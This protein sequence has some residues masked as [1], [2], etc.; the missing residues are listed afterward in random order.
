MD[1]TG[2]LLQTSLFGDLAPD[3]VEELLPDL[4]ERTYDRAETV[5]LEGDPADAVVV[6]A[7][8]QL[9]AHRLSVDGREVIVA[10]YSGVAVTGEVGAFHPAGVRW[11]GLTAMTPARCLM[12]RRAPLLDFLAR[13]PVAMRRMLESLSMAAVRAANSFSGLAFDDIGRRVAALLLAL[14]AEHGQPADDGVR[15]GLRLSQGELAAQIGATREN[16]NR[17]LVALVSGGVVSQRSGHFHVHDRVA[18]AQAARS[19]VPAG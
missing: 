3:D 8:G 4:R 7:E 2:I 18:L 13:H 5:W 15:I 16:V 14:A 6:L 12:L 17:A 10:V 1:P 9:K 19:D 11:L